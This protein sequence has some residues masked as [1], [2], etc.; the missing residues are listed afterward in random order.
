MP[1][2]VF[3]V[4]QFY[5]AKV[6]WSLANERSKVSVGL[7]KCII[8]TLPGNLKAI[9]PFIYWVVPCKVDPLNLRRVNNS[10]EVFYC[11]LCEYQEQLSSLH[12]I[13]FNIKISTEYQT[14][15]K[16]NLYQSSL[17]SVSFM[18]MTRIRCV[19]SRRDRN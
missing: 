17:I 1:F 16:E 2:P 7:C 4:F 15:A 12:Y 9:F 10:R 8:S 3:F 13:I 19:T 18:N 6:S 11:L 5:K 14:N